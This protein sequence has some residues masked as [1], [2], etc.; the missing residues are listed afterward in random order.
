MYVELSHMI[1]RLHDALLRPS[2]WDG[3]KSN[4][5]LA[6]LAECIIFSLAKCFFSL[7]SDISQLD[8]FLATDK[9][10]LL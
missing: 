5:C 3:A 2:S 7:A 8:F 9:V 4:F 1:S 10:H 6:K